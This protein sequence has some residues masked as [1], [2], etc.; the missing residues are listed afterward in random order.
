MTIPK[1]LNALAKGPG[2]VQI[3]ISETSVTVSTRYQPTVTRRGRTL[4]E[5]TI[6]VAL[7]ISHRRSCPDVKQA[8]REH[9]DYIAQVL[10]RP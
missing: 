5:A 10:G 6:A 7:A 1:L 4:E 3:N 9:E 8:V 2:G